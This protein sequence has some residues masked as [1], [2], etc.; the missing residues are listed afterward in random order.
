MEEDN[1]SLLKPDLEHLNIMSK[2]LAIKFDTRSIPKGPMI[3]FP[4]L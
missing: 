2:G 4:V 3:S 1:F